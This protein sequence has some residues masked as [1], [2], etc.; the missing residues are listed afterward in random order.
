LKISNFKFILSNGTMEQLSNVSCYNNNVTKKNIIILILLILS[1]TI[2]FSWASISR[3][4][5]GFSGR[6]DLGNME[7]TVWNTSQGRIFQMTNP[8]TG[9][10]SSRLAFHA[11]FFLILIAPVY[12]LF[13]YAETLLILQALL[14]ALGAIPVYLISKHLFVGDDLAVSPQKET[15]RPRGLSLRNNFPLLFSVM[16]LL[17]PIIERANIFEFHSEVPTVTFLLFTFYFLLIKKTRWFLIFFFLSL[18]GK[19][20]ISLNL[21]MI[22]FWGIITNKN[23]KLNIFLFIF[24]LVYFFSMIKY[25][26][27]AFNES[28]GGHFALRHFEEGS[29]GLEG[30]ISSYIKNPLL[31]ILNFTNENARSY[32]FQ[33]FSSVGFLSILSPITLL[34]SLPTILINLI[35]KD[36]QF[37]SLKYQYSA[38]I[39]PGLII[40]SIFGAKFITSLSFPRIT[41]IPLITLFFIINLHSLSPLPIIGVSPYLDFQNYSYPASQKINEWSKLIPFEKSISVTN[42]AGSHF[43]KRQ[44]LY[45]FPDHIENADYVVIAARSWQETVTAEKRDQIILELINNPKYQLIEES[46]DLWI[47]KRI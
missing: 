29:G 46:Q 28:T 47:F 38:T 10:I 4:Q 26:I 30:I 36:P 1:Y 16:Y 45:V 18:I 42:N 41:L 40:S 21:S 22:C 33:I 35:T 13:P 8:D 27:P 2:Y 24:C 43:A 37:T 23:R 31:I 32:L 25:V 6:Y 5:N 15:D 3:H 11:D 17:S 14:I 7:Q 9:N 44:N 34:F 20:T 39:V 12:K 19:E